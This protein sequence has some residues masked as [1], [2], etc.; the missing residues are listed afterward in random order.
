MNM[1]VANIIASVIFIGIGAWFLIGTLAL[2]T[3]SNA[4]DVGPRAFPLIMS[5]SIITFSIVLLIQSILSIKKGEQKSVKFTKLMNVTVF[6]GLLIL[7]A[8]LVP[9][10]GYFVSTLIFFPFIILAT[11]ERSW[12]KV[13]FI[14]IGFLAFAKLAFDMLLGVPLP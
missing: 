2:P 14:T 10:I 12:K 13:V 8:Y 9:R 1:N 3:A 6:A 4:A 7:Y 5:I 11:G